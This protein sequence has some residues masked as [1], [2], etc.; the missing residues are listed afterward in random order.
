MD[1]I[2]K[3][4]NVAVGDETYIITRVLETSDGKV[5]RYGFTTVINGIEAKLRAE[6]SSETVN[7]LYG[8]LGVQ[9]LDELTD[10]LVTEF[11]AE[12]AMIKGKQ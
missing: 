7:N 10:V 9:L 12:I 8:Q 11:Q 2:A 4:I 1:N 6:L 3:K 5:D